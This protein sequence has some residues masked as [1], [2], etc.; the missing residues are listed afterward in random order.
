MDAEVSEQQAA[1]DAF[2]EALVYDDPVQLYEQ[3]PCG[4]LSTTPDGLIVKCN[5]TF[6]TWLGLSVSETVG[7]LTFADLLAPGSRIYLETHVAPTLLMQ[8]A[9]RE[10]AMDLLDRQGRRL[11]VLMNA[12]L[13]RDDRGNPAVVRIAV[14]DAT[15]RRSYERELVRAKERAEES[16]RQARALAHTL[17]Q[18]LVPPTLPEI[19]GLEVA[20]SYRP[21]ADGL[22]VGGDFYDVFAI[23]PDDWTLVIGDVCG[24]GAEAAVVSGLVRHTVRAFAVAH[25][26]PGRVLAHVNEVLLRHGNE[27]FCTAALLRVRREGG[28]WRV[29]VANAG[30]PLSV[31]APHDGA[32]NL[33][34][35]YGP[36]LGIFEEFQAED[37]GLVLRPGDTLLLY[38]DGVIEARH[39]KEF[40]G[41]DRML[42]VLDTSAGPLPDVV[43]GLVDAVVAFERGVVGDDIA[44]L[45]VRV[46]P[47]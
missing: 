41:E 37:V 22:D 40:F 1:R 45:A 14:F 16:E 35:S 18:T 28:G 30:H 9:V 29:A 2:L 5:A 21:A 47:E 23:G 32:A 39:G 36:L 20:A 11:P 44:V 27:R 6:R 7:Q 34:G 15:D 33:V 13:V 43:R 25:D 19:P 24:K 17:Q 26:E 31:L 42:T 3:S 12:T 4:F 46:L 38:T 8:G 10:I